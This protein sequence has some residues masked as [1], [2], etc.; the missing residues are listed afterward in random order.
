MAI[1][2]GDQHLGSWMFVC[3]DIEPTIVLCRFTAK[4]ISTTVDEFMYITQK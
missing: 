1:K 2:I 3:S 4:Q